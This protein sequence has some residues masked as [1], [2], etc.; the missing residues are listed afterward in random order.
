VFKTR[1][2]EMLDIRYPIIG[3]G[4]FLLSTAELAAAVSEAGGLGIMASS[5]FTTAEGLRD[6]IR[7]AKSL[8]DKPLGVNINMFLREGSPWPN[9][10]FVEVIVEEGIKA[11]ET[12]GIRTPEDYLP[13][14]R[15]GNV[16]VI[17]K[18]T[19]VRHARKAES[20]GVDA[21]GVVGMENGG[22]VGMEDLT[23]MVV[24]PAAVSALHVPVLA[25]G[26]IGDSRGFVA[27]L[28][29]GADG[30]IIG[31]RFIATR[32]CP[33]HQSFKE[34][35]VSAKETDTVL[36]ERSIKLTHRALRNSMSD[37]V[38]EME[39][40]GAPFEEFLPFIGGESKKELFLEGKLEAGIA[41]AGQVVGLI[42]DVPTVKEV[43]ENIVNGARVVGERLASMGVL[44]E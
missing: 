18:V 30:V 15:E 26:G 9:D 10:E 5:N 24:I 1:I 2:T 21:V 14:L 31:T 42:D 34:W 8:T 44:E 40:R 20:V 37:R 39:A 13:R 28:A 22:A 16:K 36:V 17:H 27:A 41:L 25:G 4:M 33:A 7:K 35:L 3:G 23:T 38:L 29:L 43:I 12:S 11:V 6:E 19:T 32:E